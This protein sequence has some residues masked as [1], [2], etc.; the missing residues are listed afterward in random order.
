VDVTKKAPEAV[1]WA[2]D[3]AVVR[4]RVWG[5]DRAFE[6]PASGECVVGAAADCDVQL[7]DPTGCVS[8]HH[9]RLA[10]DGGAWT[11]RDLDST[12]GVREDGERRQAFQLAP[13]VEIEIG[14][15]MLVAESARLASLR[16]YLARVLGWAMRADV[17]RALRAVRE[18]ATIRATLVLCGAGELVGIARRLHGI[19]LG[20]DRAFVE[21]GA[22]GVAAFTRADRGTLCML[23]GKLPDDFAR[24]AP[25]LL[26]TS[27]RVR[28]VI[29]ANARDDAAE[30]VAA[31]GRTTTIEIPPLSARAGELAR[32][33]DAFAADAVAAHGAPG[34]CFREH[35]M[36]WLGELGLD[37]LGEIEEVTHRLVALRNWGVTEG[38]KRLGISHV[39]LSK[40][41]RR[42]KIP[43]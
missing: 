19:A 39:A 2:I 1:P 11:L 12:N 26:S 5:D 43:T 28:S 6:L 17:D 27:M 9:A 24:L 41:A 33:I 15:V 32:L 29:C 10:R 14:G 13:G 34:T 38:A 4:L 8:R 7:D 18:M 23:A 36:T 35:E 31:I 22:E 25:S 42:R 16:G 21:C 30:A 40:W 3:D 37:T 20:D